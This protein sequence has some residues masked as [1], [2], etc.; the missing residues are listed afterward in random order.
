MKCRCL[1][2]TNFT[3]K[4]ALQR[5]AVVVLRI[6]STTEITIPSSVCTR[7]REESFTD[8]ISC[9]YGRNKSDGD[10]NR[11]RTAVAR[12]GRRRRARGAAAEECGRGGRRLA[13]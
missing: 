7:K 8:G 10:D 1:A 6:R 12:R 11:R 9:R 13:I 5:L 3:R 4:L 2:P